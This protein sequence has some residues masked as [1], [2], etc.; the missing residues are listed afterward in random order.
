MD[1]F[2]KEMAKYEDGIDLIVEYN[3][4]AVILA[5]ENGIHESDN[6]LDMDEEGYEEFYACLLRIVKILEPKNYSGKLKEGG[7]TEIY[8]NAPIIEVRLTDG[9]IVWTR[10]EI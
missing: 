4:G 3:D 6:G 9:S 10:R 2:I 5:K 8:L 1:E 7:L